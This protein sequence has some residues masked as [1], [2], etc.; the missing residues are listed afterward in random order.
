V[1][2]GELVDLRSRQHVF[3]SIV[4]PSFKGLD[5]DADVVARWYPFGSERSSVVVD[6]ARS[7][8]RPIVRE[9]IPTEILALA[10]EVEG[11]VE[12]VAALYE[13][14]IQSVRDAA[15]FQRQLAA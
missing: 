4:A 13:I 3:R 2:E 11:S 7:F 8:G 6:P 14:P 12:R 15:D 5:F 10:M 1:R 9:G